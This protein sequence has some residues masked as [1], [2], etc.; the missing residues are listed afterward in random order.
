M[1]TFRG[2]RAKSGGIEIRWQHQGVQHSRFIN[3]APTQTNIEDAVRQRKKFIELCKL[4]S[5]EEENQ[6]SPTFIEV[7]E[8][9]LKY[10]AKN[11]KQSTL[12][13]MQSKLN[14]HWECLFD[15]VLEEITLKDLRNAE[16]K[17]ENIKPK[18][19]KNSISDLKQVFKY[20]MDEDIIDV[21]PSVKLKPPKFQ[22]KAIDSFSA[23]ERDAIIEALEGKFQLFYLFMMDSGMRTGEVQGLKWTDIKDEYAH[24]ERSI[25]RGEVTTTKTHQARRVLLSPRTTKAIKARQ[26][27]RFK[28]PWIF[29]PRGTDLPYATDKAITTQF[30]SACEKAKVRYRRPYY[31][32]H[33]YVTLALRSG[34]TPIAVA[35]QIGDRLETMQKNYADIMSEHNDKEE[36]KKAH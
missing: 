5:Y 21:D 24:V 10:K 2:V 13:A 28:S 7:A 3:K 16:R 33:T 32:R 27:D 25:Y 1:A 9:M 23:T 29:S 11:L 18:T 35:K 8:E 12:D 20:A 19:K 14:N 26:A 6:L 30:K 34:V 36:L 31:C 15:L 22:K 17:I 4:G